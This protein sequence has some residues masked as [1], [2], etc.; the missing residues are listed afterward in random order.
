E[1][2]PLYKKITEIGE[3]G[4]FYWNETAT[5][6]ELLFSTGFL[7]ENQKANFIVGT[8]SQKPMRRETLCF[9]PIDKIYQINRYQLL[10]S[11]KGD[12]QNSAGAL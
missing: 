2:N 11:R 6:G 4:S 1:L 8:Q 9:S 3:R 10:S 7:T 12:N 5:G